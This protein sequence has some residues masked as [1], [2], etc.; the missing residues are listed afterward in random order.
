MANRSR[1]RDPYRGWHTGKSAKFDTDSRLR[2]R[3]LQD[4]LAAEELV[5]PP[6][7]PQP[8]RRRRKDDCGRKPGRVHQWGPWQLRWRGIPSVTYRCCLRCSKYDVD[9]SRWSF[10]EALRTTPTPP[11]S[12]PSSA[13]RGP[14]GSS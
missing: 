3:A 1:T 4:E 11:S 7:R 2:Q 13:P 14:S 9:W 8:R 10:R 6:A 12:P 5:V